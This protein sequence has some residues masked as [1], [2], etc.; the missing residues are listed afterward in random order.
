MNRFLSVYKGFYIFFKC[1]VQ[2]E[3]GHTTGYVADGE[4]VEVYFIIIE[5]V[6]PTFCYLFLCFLLLKI[7]KN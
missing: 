3:Y 2:N 5:G 1:N 7:Y 6:E 4:Q